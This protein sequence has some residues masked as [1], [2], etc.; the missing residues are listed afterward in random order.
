MCAP[1]INTD[2]PFYTRMVDAAEW[3]SGR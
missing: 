2:H 3:W 1:V